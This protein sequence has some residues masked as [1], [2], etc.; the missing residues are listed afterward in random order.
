MGLQRESSLGQGLRN[1]RSRELIADYLILPV[2]P[3]FLDPNG[4]AGRRPAG[5]QVPPG[6]I[7]LLGAGGILS[8]PIYEIV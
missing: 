3:K 6:V 5:T 2:F 7:H 8:R 1:L 4:K